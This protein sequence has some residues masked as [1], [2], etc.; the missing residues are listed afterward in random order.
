MLVVLSALLLQVAPDT[1]ALRGARSPSYAPDGRLILAMD[2]DVFLQR[3]P[4]AALVRVTRGLPWDR[5]PVWT[6]DGAAIVYA[7]DRGDHYD[8]WRVAVTADGTAGAPERLTNTPQPETAPTTAPDGSIAFV[9]G[10][11]NAARVWIRDASG[12]ER[13]LSTRE[14]NFFGTK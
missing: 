12:K 7:S 5:D 11:G 3:T 6:R 9:R 1:A 2:G 4:G 8:L 13:R 14:I 10:S